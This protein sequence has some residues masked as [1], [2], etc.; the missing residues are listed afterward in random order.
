MEAAGLYDIAILAFQI[1][2]NNAIDF[3][4]QPPS[5]VK[6]SSILKTDSATAHPAFPLCKS[7]FYQSVSWEKAGEKFENVLLYS[8]ECEQKAI[9]ALPCQITEYKGGKM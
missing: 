4:F 9:F 2:R 1:D 7:P 8:S 6:V 5:F 3:D